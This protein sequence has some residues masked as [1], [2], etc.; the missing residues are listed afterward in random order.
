MT[1]MEKLRLFVTD[2]PPTVPGNQVM[3]GRAVV[4]LTLDDL[5]TIT[6]VSAPP[7]VHKM[8]PGATL[9]PKKE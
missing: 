9:S 2:V 3:F 1:P 8:V 7:V 4:V 5:R 6:G